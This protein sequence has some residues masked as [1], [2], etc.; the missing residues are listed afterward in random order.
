MKPNLFFRDRGVVIRTRRSVA[1]P[2]VL[3]AITALIALYAA[4]QALDDASN[5]ACAQP[6]QQGTKGRP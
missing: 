1:W 2:W 4:M 3:T 6:Q 5:R